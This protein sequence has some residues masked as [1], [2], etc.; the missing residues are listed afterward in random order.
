M[1]TTGTSPANQTYVD[2]LAMMEDAF[3]YTLVQPYDTPHATALVYRLDL[4][5]KRWSKV[6][7]ERLYGVEIDCRCEA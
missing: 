3:M 4:Q 7:R 5:K 6:S 2:G 1:T